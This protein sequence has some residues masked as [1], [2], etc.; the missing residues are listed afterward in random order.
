MAEP[1]AFKRCSTCRK[2]I[3]FEQAYYRCSVSTCNGKRTGLFFC[4]VE[5]WQAHVPEARHR[6]AWAEE[7]RS[8]TQAEWE[9]ERSGESPPGETPRRRVVTPAPEPDAEDSSE[10]A[11]EVL[12]VTSKLKAFIR[13][14]SGM[15]TS[16]RVV[17]V[18]SD[19]LRDLSVRALR[20]ASAEGRKTVLDRDFAAVL[21]DLGL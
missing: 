14:R 10:E 9:R 15:N 4:T 17:G 12:I 21:K 16:D 11:R 20:H 5:C 1:G 6:D 3:G 8:P 13:A 18:L 19:H 2:P 7:E